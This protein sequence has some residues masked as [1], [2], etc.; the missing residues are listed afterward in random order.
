MASVKFRLKNPKA[1]SSLIVA[2]FYSTQTG[3]LDFSTG[4]NVPPSFWE[5]QRVSSK[6]KKQADRINRHLSTIEADLLDVWRDNKGASKEVLS[7]L[8]RKTVKGGGGAEKKTFIEAVRL[9]IAQYER[10]KDPS[11]VGRY[12]VLERKLETFNLSLT[13]DDLNQ[14]FY[15]EFKLWL[16]GNHNPLYTGFNLRRDPDGDGY[17][18]TRGDSPTGNVGLFDDVVFKYIVNIQTILHWAEK[19]GYQV[20]PAYKSWEIIK[21]DYP[22]ISLTLDELQRIEDLNNL[23]THLQ[24]A[25]DYLSLACR[26]GQRISDVKR[27]SALSISSGTWTIHQKKGSRQKQKVVQLPLVGFSSPVIDIVNKYGGKLPEISEQ[28]LNYHIKEV[29]KLAGITQEIY[30]ERWQGNKKIKIP[31]QKWEYISSHSGKKTFITILSSLGAP[32]SVLAD[33]TGTSQKTIEKHYLG[34][35]PLYVAEKYLMLGELKN[36]EGQKEIKKAV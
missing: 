16:Y 28:N 7:A 10:E 26:T 31:G 17:I 32:L 1:A 35:T 14:T 20:N 23:P 6:Y 29:C 9:F 5:G 22:I 33:F 11:T 30:I 21:R 13:F 18:L 19:R 24:I 25:K 3:P 12:R 34:R 8:V 27:I 4:E 36:I 2:R 15:D